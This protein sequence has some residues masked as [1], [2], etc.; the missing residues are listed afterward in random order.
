M[1]NMQVKQIQLERFTHAIY[2]RLSEELVDEY[3]NQLD[4]DISAHS[5][6]DVPDYVTRI[7]TRSFGRMLE[8]KHIK[9]PATWWDAFKL[10]VLPYW[11]RK[12]LKINYTTKT[13]TARECLPKIPMTGQDSVILY[14]VEGL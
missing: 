11:L 2:V 14:S 5:F 7:T 3:V 1:D 9:Y 13:L 8:E 12:K 6:F 4:V 10:E